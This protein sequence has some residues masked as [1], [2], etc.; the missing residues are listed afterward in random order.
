MHKYLVYIIYHD[1]HVTCDRA[2]S[3]V[4]HDS[5]INAT[6]LTVDAVGLVSVVLAD[7]PGA[8]RRGPTF[9]AP[10]CLYVCIY[11]C[12]YVRMYVCLYICLY[13]CMYV[14]MYESCHTQAAGRSILH[15][16]PLY[17]KY[18]H[19]FLHSTIYSMQRFT[20]LRGSWKYTQLRNIAI[21]FYTSTY[22]KTQCYV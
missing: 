15:C 6:G 18:I 19:A 5:F 9:F 8:R 21:I 4:Q 16:S 14:C 20:G 7:V 10:V 3:R 22:K 13:V 17:S 1:T 11:V 12:L 2:H